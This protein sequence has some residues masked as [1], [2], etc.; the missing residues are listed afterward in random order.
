MDNQA[1]GEAQRK[2]FY[3]SFFTGKEVSLRDKL[4]TALK[5]LISLGL[6]A[7]LFTRIDLAEVK[8]ALAS[9]H[10][11]YLVLALVL[12]FVAIALNVYKWGYLLQAQGLAVPLINLLNHTFVG[13]FFANLPLSQ[14]MGDI[15]RGVDLAR[16]TQGHGAEVA[17]SVLMDRLIGLASFL[18]ASVVMLAFA[19]FSL[20]RTDLTSLW[21]TVLLVLLAFVIALAVLLSRRLR[22]LVEP[23][24]K[25]Q[26]LNRFTAL[27]RNLSGAVQMYRSNIGALAVA[28]FIALL[29]VLTTN[30]V[31]FLAAESVQ[32]AIPLLWVFVFNPLTPIAQ[33]IPSIGS[34]L[35]VNQGVFV[36]LYSFIGGVTGQPQALAMS[37]VMQMIIYIASLP[38]G[39]LWWRTRKL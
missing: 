36:L 31:N 33:F 18:F 12:Y 14:V 21:V 24:F 11:L 6:I 26:P 22:G 32:A 23:L 10:Y 37:L 19:V 7:Y 30:V 29:G 1:G 39:V 3:P 17:V 8:T 27:Y 34:G 35:G 4:F 13:L 9:A 5:V 28:F 38:G 2:R 15:A 25:W 20:G 16:H